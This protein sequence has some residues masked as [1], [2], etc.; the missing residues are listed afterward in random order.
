MNSPN[1]SINISLGNE[2]HRLAKK[3]ATEAKQLVPELEKEA[4]GQRVYLNT[5]A[6]YA[7]NHYLTR[8]AYKTELEGSESWNLWGRSPLDVAALKVTGIGQL[9]CCPVWEAEAVFAIPSAATEGRIAYLPVQFGEQLDRAELLGFARG[10]EILADTDLFFICDL[11]SLEELIDYLY[12]IESATAFFQEGND[13]LAIEFR[14]KMGWELLLKLV[15]ELEVI[16]RNE[17]KNEQTYRV[18]NLLKGKLVGG[19]R[20]TATEPEDDSKW[21]D[22]AATLLE[23]LREIWEATP[24]ED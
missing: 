5:L 12:R 3:F 21:L 23:K 19:D 20:L 6:V 18:K 16:Y 17:S 9:E 14:Q 1:N 15:L 10:I 4:T 11:H 13:P 2:A 24:D 22:L 7:V 8:L